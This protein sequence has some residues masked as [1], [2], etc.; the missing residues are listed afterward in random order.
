MFHII[1]EVTL[2]YLPSDLSE[3][4]DGRREKWLTGEVHT[5]V[6]NQPAYHFGEYYVLAHYAKFG[7]QGH[8]FYALG[9][10]EP[11]NQKLVDGRNA[12]AQCFDRDKLNDFRRRRVEC[13][14]ADGKGEPDLFLHHPNGSTLFL[15]VKKGSDRVSLEQLECLAQIR[16]ILHA[17]VG[18]VYL[19]E[20]DVPYRPKRY[21]LDLQRSVGKAIKT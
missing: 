2:E 6:S 11:R 1:E 18:I 9:D 21:E 20:A 17:D 5:H 8:R 19:V 7:W 14:R 16:A 10:W 12:I 3:W 15:E 4:K 13:G